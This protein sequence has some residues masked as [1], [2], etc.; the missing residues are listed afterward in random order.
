LL[1]A[2]CA[3]AVFAIVAFFLDRSK[4]REALASV[5]RAVLR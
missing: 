2:V 5:R 1:A 3:L 4:L